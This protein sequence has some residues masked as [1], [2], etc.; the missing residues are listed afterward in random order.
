MPQQPE[1]EG[2]VPDVLL[3]LVLFQELLR[4]AQ[5]E[6]HL[7]EL[8]TA[9]VHH[10]AGDERGDAELHGDEERVTRL[11]VG[12]ESAETLEGLL[13]GGDARL[14]GLLLEEGADLLVGDVLHARASD[15]G[16]A[17]GLVVLDLLLVLLADDDA[18][19]DGDEADVVLRGGVA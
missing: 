8:L 15:R 9:G 6:G 4:V 17:G 19:M 16:R 12:G 1:G 14:L 18:R 7:P 2:P 5:P 11:G 3:V 13:V 10:V